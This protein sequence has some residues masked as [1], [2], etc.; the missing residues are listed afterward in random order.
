MR[1]LAEVVGRTRPS[2]RKASKTPQGATVVYGEVVAVF[3]PDA[4][5]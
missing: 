3:L 2:H 1:E 5:G 4:K